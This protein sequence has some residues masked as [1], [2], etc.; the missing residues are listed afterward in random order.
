MHFL[1][2]F[3]TC[4]AENLSDVTLSNDFFKHTHAIGTATKHE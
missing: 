1:H 4:F 2:C 3:R